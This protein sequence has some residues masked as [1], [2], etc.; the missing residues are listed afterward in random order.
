MISMA[1]ARWTILLL[2][3][4]MLLPAQTEPYLQVSPSNRLPIKQG[5]ERYARDQIKRN[6]SDLFEIKIPGY[7]VQTEYDDLSGTVPVLGKPDFA[8]IMD[9]AVSNGSKPYMQTFRLTSITPVSGGYEIRG[10]SKAQRESF[11][12]KGILAFTAYESDGQI[13]FGAW[14]FVYFMPHSCSQ[15]SDSER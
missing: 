8:R 11:H 7:A 13:R 5:I 10:C 12:F 4:P 2:F 15:T 14:R 6:W 1:F 9:E 3:L